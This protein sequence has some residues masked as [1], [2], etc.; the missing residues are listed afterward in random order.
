VRAA[1]PGLATQGVAFDAS[2]SEPDTPLL[3]DRAGFEQVVTNLV[4]N[5]AQAAGAGG[6]V[7][8][9]AHRDGDSY[10]V[11]VEDNGADIREEHFAR[12]FEPFFTTKP[13]GQGVGLGLS[14][15]L[16]I[17]R[18]HEGTLLAENRSARSGGGARFIMR[19]PL[20]NRAD[21]PA[22]AAAA[23]ATAATG[24]ADAVTATG[25]ASA[26]AGVKA[27]DEGPSNPMPPRQPSLLVIDDEDSIRRALRRYFERRGWAVDEAPD[28]TGALVKLLRRDA[29][30]LYDVVLCDLKM[31]GVSGP[32]LY[33]RLQA[34]SPEMV[35]RLILSTGDVSAPDIVDFLAGVTVPV[36]DKP[37]ELSTLEKLADKVR[38]ETGEDR[39]D[40][41]PAKSPA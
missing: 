7:R 20:A 10:V 41:T 13:T 18:G 9:V 35:R 6:A 32:E 19:L 22:A 3:L 25:K 30:V 34:E 12:I 4:T 14:A 11:V 38:R 26:A 40:R 17:V 15:S 27:I 16:S 5:A 23:A 2:V 29:N 33:R 37:F 24:P 8:L 21:E 36:L 39:R 28:G 31:P 1:R